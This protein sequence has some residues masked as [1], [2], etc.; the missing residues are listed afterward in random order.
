M[1][2]ASARMPITSLAPSPLTFN[3]SNRFSLGVE[4]ELIAVHPETLL[5]CG[6]TDDLLERA[7]LAPERVTGEVTDGVLELR[8][9]LRSLLRGRTIV[10]ADLVEVITN[11]KAR[12]G[13][14]NRSAFA[15]NLVDAQR[16]RVRGYFETEV[17]AATSMT[18]P[19]PCFRLRLPC[20]R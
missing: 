20:R 12:P 8:T 11:A 4:E 13:S 7:A 10:G 19:S 18:A 6:G 5:P 14:L 15:G 9:L 3:G 17:A 2:T 1:G 16:I